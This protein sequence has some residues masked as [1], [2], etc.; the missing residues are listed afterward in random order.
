MRLQEVG[1]VYS[2]KPVDSTDRPL[3]VHKTGVIALGT[4]KSGSA[5]ANEG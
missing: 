3:Q 4:A 5:G 2:H 1:E